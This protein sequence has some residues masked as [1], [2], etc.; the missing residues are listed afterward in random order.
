MKNLTRAIANSYRPNNGNSVSQK[1]FGVSAVLLTLAIVTTGLGSKSF[2]AEPS[3]PLEKLVSELADKP[4]QH[5]AI[6]HYY[7]EKA[8]AARKEAAEHKRMGNMPIGHSQSALAQKDWRTHCEKLSASLEATA[9]EYDA[10]AK[11]H[12]GDASKGKSEMPQQHMMMHQSGDAQHEGH[13]K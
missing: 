8:A 9:K 2:A 1:R 7:Q 10:L 4:E 3:E 13:S 5:T 12:E 6:A 11:L